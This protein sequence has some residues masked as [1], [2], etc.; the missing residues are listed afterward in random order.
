M[1]RLLSH[2]VCACLIT[3]GMP[4]TAPLQAQEAPPSIAILPIQGSGVS[5]ENTKMLNH[6]LRKLLA[7]KYNRSQM[8]YGLIDSSNAF[9]CHNIQCAAEK[10]R[11]LK[12]DQVIFGQVRQQQHD[13]DVQLTLVDTRSASKARSAY[14]SCNYCNFSR[15]LKSLAPELLKEMSF[16]EA[17]TPMGTSSQMDQWDNH[18]GNQLMFDYPPELE[19]KEEVLSHKSNIYSYLITAKENSPF[20]VIILEQKR[21]D[22]SFWN[23]LNFYKEQHAKEH[24]LNESEKI[25]F[26]LGNKQVEAIPYTSKPGTKEQ[27]RKGFLLLFENNLTLYQIDLNTSLGLD[28]DKDQVIQQFFSNFL[29]TLYVS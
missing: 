21:P 26:S 29:K 11:L 9:D 23:G 5:K 16:S 2:L 18:V 10:G 3:L 4:Y 14:E 20:Y 22:T 27:P 6:R 13:Y 24:L 12:V 28:K 1:N 17:T 7:R 15:V 19:V 8:D 25:R